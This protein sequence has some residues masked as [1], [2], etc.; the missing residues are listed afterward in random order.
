MSCIYVPASCM[1][2]ILFCPAKPSERFRG[3]EHR[4][5]VS[6]FQEVD[7]NFMNY[8]PLHFELDFSPLNLNRLQELRCHFSKNNFSPLAPI[9]HLKL[10]LGLWHG[11]VVYWLEV[12]VNNQLPYQLIYF[13]TYVCKDKFR[14]CFRGSQVSILVKMLASSQVVP[15][16]MPASY[17]VCQLNQN[18]E[19]ISHSTLQSI[20]FLQYFSSQLMLC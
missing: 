14:A 6:N 8:H 18:D 17:L 9:L 1:E 11:V 16:N 3:F 4:G 20:S 7:K 13:P 19:S 5:T 2:P 10:Q 15:I 12:I